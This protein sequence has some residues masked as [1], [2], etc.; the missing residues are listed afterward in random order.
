[1]ASLCGAQKE[2]TLKIVLTALFQAIIIELLKNKHIHKST[3]K[4]P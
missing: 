3:L 2:E 1:M 4:V